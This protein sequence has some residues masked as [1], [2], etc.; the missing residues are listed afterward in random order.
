M[1]KGFCFF[2]LLTCLAAP[3]LVAAADAPA[4]VNAPATPA[5]PDMITLKD[6][7]GVLYGEVVEMTDGV[8]YMKTAAAED[9]I[10]KIKWANVEKLVINR[11]IPFHLKKG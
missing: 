8:L 2:V 9:K 1:K 7:G 11:Q 4:V 5:P 3:Q 6:G 10:I